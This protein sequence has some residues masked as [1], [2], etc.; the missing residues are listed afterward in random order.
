MDHKALVNFA[1]SAS[2]RRALVRAGRLRCIIGLLRPRDKRAQM[3][4][5]VAMQKLAAAGVGTRDDPGGDG[6]AEL[7]L[8]EHALQ[9]LLETMARPDDE[10]R[11]QAVREADACAN[12]TRV[13]DA[14]HF[15]PH[16]LHRQS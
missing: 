15:Q 11:Q 6:Y 16:R 13:G 2:A 3:L 5:L 8:E 7:L 9:P 14:G 4:G 10:L 12:E 1:S